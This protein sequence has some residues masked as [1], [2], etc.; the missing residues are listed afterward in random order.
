MQFLIKHRSTLYII[1]YLVLLSILIIVAQSCKENEE[2]DPVDDEP[3]EIKAIIGPDGGTI[4]LEN[5]RVILKIPKDALP[6]TTVEISITEVITDQYTDVIQGT[7]FDLGPSGLQFALPVTLTINMDPE[8]VDVANDSTLFIAK[9]LDGGNR[10]L[11]NSKMTGNALTADI[12]SFSRLVVYYLDACGSKSCGRGIENLTTTYNQDRSI[13]LNWN[14]GYNAPDVTEIQRA[15]IKGSFTAQDSDFSTYSLTNSFPG[16]FVDRNIGNEGAF[17][18]YRIRWRSGNVFGPF[19]NIVRETVFGD[20]NECTDFTIGNINHASLPGIE[21]SVRVNLNRLNGFNGNINLDLLSKDGNLP[22]QEI[23]FNYGFETNQQTGDIWL[24][25]T[26]A[27]WTA[28]QQFEFTI[29]GFTSDGSSAC[30]GNFTLNVNQPPSPSVM[31]S[32]FAG[33]GQSGF[34]DG[35]ADNARFNLPWGLDQ[36]GGVIYVADLENHSIRAIDKD[37]VVTT[38]AGNGTQGYQDG[39]SAQFAFPIDILI[40]EQEKYAYVADY[41]NHVI[42]RIELSTGSTIT[43]AGTGNNGFSDGS[44]LNAELHFPAGM[45]MINNELY[46]ADFGNNAIRKVSIEENPAD[47][48]VSTYAGTGV[49]GS[50]DGSAAQASF[51]GPTDLAYDENAEVMYVVDKENN[52]IRTIDN[53]GLVDTPWGLEP[54]ANFAFNLITSIE[55]DQ[56]GNVYVADQTHVIRKFTPCGGECFTNDIWMGSFNTPGFVDGV[57]EEARF[58]V[59][60]ALQVTKLEVDQQ[61]VEVML[62]SDGDNHAIRMI[63]MP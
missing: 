45:A 48:I 25:Y 11:Y 44:A 30:N 15:V 22:S 8:N 10:E 14:Y 20:G 52:S 60:T 56:N 51:H 36:A 4:N 23:F 1:F 2:V 34:Q 13:T 5:G 27:N 31:V 3:A 6:D 40:D 63:Q 18:F 12:R 43:Y 57:P 59:V 39:A 19:S 28:G 33:D 49:I 42:R 55:V 29:R 37:T 47:A 46:F 26:L 9:L 21:D 38:F 61:N 24:H 7:I 32:T 53:T 41:G 17:Y 16:E 54:P 62:I 35:V 50:D 58:N